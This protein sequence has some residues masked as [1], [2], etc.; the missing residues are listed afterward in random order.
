MLSDDIIPSFP[1]LPNFEFVLLLYCTL[2]VSGLSFMVL[3]IYSV[4][5]TLTLKA[6]ITTAADDKFGDNF[7]NFRQK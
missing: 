1:V 3:K 6:P 5:L 2:P 7:P 4:L